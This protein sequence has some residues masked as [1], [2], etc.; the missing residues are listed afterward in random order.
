MACRLAS[1]KPKPRNAFDAYEQCPDHYPNIKLLLQILSTLP[2]TSASAERSF[3]MLRRLKSWLRSTMSDDR[4]TS[5]ALLA[6]STDIIVS[7]ED[8]VDRL[9]SFEESTNQYCAQT[10]LSTPL[11]ALS[12]S[13]FHARFLFLSCEICDNCSTIR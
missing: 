8:V 7:P 6:T 2:V 3:S 9:F 13:L 11:S 4:L 12:S 5:L 1:D 10:T